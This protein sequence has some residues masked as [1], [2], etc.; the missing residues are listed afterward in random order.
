MFIHWAKVSTY[1]PGWRY[2]KQRYKWITELKACLLIS[3]RLLVYKKGAKNRTYIRCDIVNSARI[4]KLLRCEKKK[5]NDTKLRINKYACLPFP[6]S[7]LLCFP[8]SKSWNKETE[9]ILETPLGGWKS[10][11]LLLNQQMYGSILTC[12]FSILVKRSFLNF[13][14]FRIHLPMRSRS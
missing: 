6:F 14:S 4:Q 7:E 8:K 9:L 12:T 5:L 10:K 11:I 3:H 1:W 2:I 13:S